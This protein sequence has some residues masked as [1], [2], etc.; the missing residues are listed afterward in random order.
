MKINE[1]D[2]ALQ[3]VFW[4]SD[5]DFLDPFLKYLETQSQKNKTMI[6][7]PNNDLINIVDVNCND[8]R[9]VFWQILVLKFGDYGTSPQY[10]W[11]NKVPECLEYVKAFQQRMHPEEWI[12]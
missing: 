1:T 5:C 6:R 3:G 7:F 9:S 12:K 10:G 8:I 11:I 4:Y 2:T